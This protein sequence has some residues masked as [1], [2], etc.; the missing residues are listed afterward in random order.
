MGR[1]NVEYCVYFWLAHIKKEI[2][3]LEKVQK[4]GTKII[5]VLES[6]PYEVFFQFS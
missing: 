6:L 2:S 4:R 3:G 5:K 1:P